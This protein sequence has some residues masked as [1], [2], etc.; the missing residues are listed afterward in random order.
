ML[1]Y[2]LIP[3]SKYWRWV[4]V[5]LITLFFLADNSFIAYM[6]L[7]DAV[8]GRIFLYTM[9]KIY[10]KIITALDKPFFHLISLF[11]FMIILLWLVI[12]VFNWLNFNLYI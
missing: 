1:F 4:V 3:G 11:I 10:E 6:L 2:T 5:V 9:P 12:D 8:V 7:I